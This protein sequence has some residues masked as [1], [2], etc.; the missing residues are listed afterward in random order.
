MNASRLR[1]SAERRVKLGRV[2]FGVR[3]FKNS[4]SMTAAKSF[5][6]E[7]WNADP[8]R[9]GVVVYSLVPNNNRP[10]WAAAIL[11]AC[12]GRVSTIPKPIR[13]VLD[14]SPDSA[15]WK[16]A[17]DAFSGVRQLT[18]AAEHCPIETL[19]H[20]LLYVAENTAKVIYNASGSSAPFDRDSGAWLVRCAKEF[21]DC[22]NDASFTTSL[23]T[24]ITTFPAIEPSA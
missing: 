9:A 18:L 7:E 2:I 20:Y 15:K 13:H 19:D 1:C 17:H 10:V 23:W 4:R 3:Q 22:V 12:C 6:R 5:S 16:L 21:A 11:C 14:L 24:T 8:L